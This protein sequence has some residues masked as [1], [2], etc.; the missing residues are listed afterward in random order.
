MNRRSSGRKVLD[1]FFFPLR[2]V[3]LFHE[4]RWGLSCQASERFDYVAREV[5]GYCLDVGCG[6]HNRFLKEYRGDDGQGIDVFAYEGLAAGNIVP[7]LTHL[8]FADATFDSV[9]FIANLNHC[10]E[11]DRDAELRESWRVLKPGGN[12]I[13]SMGHPVAEI[14][15]HK[16]IW[17]YDKVFKTSYDMD[18]ERGMHEDE[19]YYLLDGEILDRLGRAGFGRVR[20]KYFLTQWGLN[21]LF[22]GWKPEIPPEID[23][24]GL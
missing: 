10:P 5:R 2:A 13:I 1:F 14:L 12:V 18:N 24:L 17:A 3:T 22:V 21:H 16:L 7:D 20:K 4:D 6:R 19:D 23:A 8:P 9:T 11:P 15:V